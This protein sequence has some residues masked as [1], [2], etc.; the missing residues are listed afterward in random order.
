M[1]IKLKILKNINKNIFIINVINNLWIISVKY[2]IKK[3]IFLINKYMMNVNK[4]INNVVNAIN[5]LLM[6]KWQCYLNNNVINNVMI[7]ILVNLILN[8]KNIVK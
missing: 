3:Q 6:I 7:N 5:I 8:D 1:L 4:I 2:V